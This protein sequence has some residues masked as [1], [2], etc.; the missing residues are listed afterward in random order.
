MKAM[1]KHKAKILAKKRNLET[2]DETNKLGQIR[3]TENEDQ[4]ADQTR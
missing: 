2:C 1:K 4:D 3:E